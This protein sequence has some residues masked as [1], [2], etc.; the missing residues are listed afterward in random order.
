LRLE[1]HGFDPRPLRFF[2][3]VVLTRVPLSPI[4][5]RSSGGDALRLG[6]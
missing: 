3:Q 4:W 1:G 6:R 5:Y 2:G